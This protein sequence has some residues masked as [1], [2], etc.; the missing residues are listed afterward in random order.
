MSFDF[1]QF[2]D[3]DDD[4][5]VHDIEAQWEE[6]LKQFDTTGTF[7]FE[8][9]EEEQTDINNM[10]KSSVDESG[11]QNTVQ[12]KMS[13]DITQFDAD[14]SFDF[15]VDAEDDEEKENHR[16]CNALAAEEIVRIVKINHASDDHLTV[17][18]ILKKNK[19]I[20]NK[21]KSSTLTRIHGHENNSDDTNIT[22]LLTKEEKSTSSENDTTPMKVELVS[23][24]PS[25]SSLYEQHKELLRQR[26]SVPS[27]SSPSSSFSSSTSTSA[28]FSSESSS[29]SSLM[30]VKD[31]KEDNFDD[32]F[33]LRLQNAIR[34]SSS[35]VHLQQGKNISTAFA[36]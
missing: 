11:I 27:P 25:P 18:N 33:S 26:Y 35:F 31:K 1:N 17:L 21:R 32:G 5:V 6:A 14:D 8:E 16:R 24:N 19:N 29:S 10:C 7:D 28:A 2:D 4:C 34:T 9:M 15:E 36:A 3:D 23:N 20:N 22:K 12:R 30:I 13:F